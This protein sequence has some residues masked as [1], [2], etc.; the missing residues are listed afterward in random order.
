MVIV[1]ANRTGNCSRLNSNGTSV[2][3][4]EM[5][6]MR[7]SSPLYFP[8]SIVASITLFINFFIANHVP[9]QRRG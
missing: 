3:I 7:T 8:F 6:G 1:K 2:G 9:L 4:I 5:H